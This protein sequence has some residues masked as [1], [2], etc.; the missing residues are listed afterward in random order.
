MNLSEARGLALIDRQAEQGDLAPAEYEVARQAI[1]ATGD[2][3]Y[4]TLLRFSE[5][6]LVEGAAALAARGPLVTDVPAVQ[7]AILPSLGETFL[8]P[9]YCCSESVPDRGLPA[10]AR[11][12]PEG[13]FALGESAVVLGALIHA[14]GHGNCKP[15]LVIATPAGWFERSTAKKRLMVSGVPWICSEGSKGG[16]T[17]TAAIVNSLATLAWQIYR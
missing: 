14:I 1:L 17:V 3:E 10:L 16:A 7:A 6:A 4:R 5:R 15:S 12:F 8:N 9:V 11:R 13:I 2:L